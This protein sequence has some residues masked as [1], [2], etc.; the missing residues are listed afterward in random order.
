M[1]EHDE[2]IQTIEKVGEGINKRLDV[3]NGSVAKHE[4]RFGSQDVLNAQM[5]I[6][7]Q[8][9]VGD[10]STIKIETKSSA[11]FRTEA[12]ATI[13]VFKWL[14][15]TIGIGTLITLFKILS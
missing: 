2:V 13:N 8:Q 10:L 3:L 12:K 14:I 1:K 11:D 6:T 7:Q 5:T 4:A 15:G 9:I